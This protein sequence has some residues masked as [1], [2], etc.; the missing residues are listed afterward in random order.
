MSLSQLYI[1]FHFQISWN[2]V[3]SCLCMSNFSKQNLTP[4]EN[5]KL[6][7]NVIISKIEFF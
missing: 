4:Y 5:K 2:Q 3:T 7:Q 6:R 1:T